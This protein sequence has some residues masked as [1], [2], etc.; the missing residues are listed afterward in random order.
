MSFRGVQRWRPNYSAMMVKGGAVDG[1]AELAKA[2]VEAPIMRR[3]I[4]LAN[5]RQAA[6]DAERAEDR[7]MRREEH[8]AKLAENGK[9]EKVKATQLHGITSGLMEHARRAGTVKDSDGIETF[10]ET[11]ARKEYEHLRKLV[12]AELRGQIP[13]YDGGMAGDTAAPA[14]QEGALDEPDRP[15]AA[16]PGADHPAA[17]A[18]AEVDDGADLDADADEMADAAAGGGYQAP[19]QGPMDPEEQAWSDYATEA[20]ENVADGRQPNAGRRPAPRT[21]LDRGDM[22]DFVMGDQDQAPVA[23][24]RLGLQQG[25]I[26]Q[27]RAEAEAQAAGADPMLGPPAP[28][29]ADRAKAEDQMIAAIVPALHKKDQAAWQRVLASKDPRRIQGARQALLRLARPA[30][31]RPD[32]EPLGDADLA[33]IG[34]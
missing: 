30:G 23:G 16:A 1:L 6:A 9:P 12:P 2:F 8:A 34:P 5:K 4:E 20:A 3:K 22:A 33:G 26:D 18:L 15:A 24:A 19:I 10:D 29:A 17:A 28:A 31:A 13:D 14:A 27:G 21:R 11:A 25:E 7:R 32:D